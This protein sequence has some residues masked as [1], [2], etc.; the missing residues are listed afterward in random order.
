MYNDIEIIWI[1]TVKYIPCYLIKYEK[2][3]ENN[4]NRY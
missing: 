3:S 2:S 4:F 1:N